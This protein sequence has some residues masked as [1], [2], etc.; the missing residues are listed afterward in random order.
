MTTENENI[1][2]EG[3]RTEQTPETETQ[4]HIPVS[5]PQ[6][7]AEEKR[8]TKPVVIYLA[9]LAIVVAGLLTLSYFMQHRNN[10]ELQNL[11]QTFQSTYDAM[12]T[13]NDMQVTISDQTAEINS[14][15][16]QVETYEEQ[17]EA[18]EEQVS[19]L[20][21]Q[22]EQAQTALTEA[23]S[24]AETNDREIQALKYL[25]QLE[26]AYAQEDLERCKTILSEM[27]SYA[28]ALTGD[29]LTRYQTLVQW[30][31]AEE[32]G[33]TATTSPVISEY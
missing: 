1:H 10:E 30:V 8:R 5:P 2:Q 28:D 32:P 13:I 17:I 18:Y 22:L 11:T 21:T 4:H 19:D 25:V 31:E 24:A 27:E 20:E 6:L 14:L 26:Q 33:E 15:E 29:E 12:S 7:T 16:D 3:Q 23:E 9:L